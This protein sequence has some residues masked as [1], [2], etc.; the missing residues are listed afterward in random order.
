[1]KIVTAQDIQDKRVFIR[2][3]LDVPI[4][5]GVILDDFRL[6]AAVPTLNLCLQHAKQIV[7][8][9]H[10]GRPDGVEVPSLSVGPIYEWLE[11]HLGPEYMSGDHLQLLENLRFDKGE[12]FDTATEEEVLNQAKQLASLA[13]IYVNE[14]FASHHKSASTTVLPTLLPHFAGLRFAKEVQMLTMIRSN[15]LKPFISIV[16]GIKLEDKLP[17]VMVLAKVSDAVLVGGKI[18]DQ[19]KQS[20]QPI[21]ENI[22]PAELTPDGFDI[23][24]QTIDKWE[25]LINNSRMILWNGPMGKVEDPKN[26]QTKRLAELIIKSSAQTIVGGGDSISAL[27]KWGMI[28]KFNFVSTGGGAMLKFIES[29][30]LDTIKA[31]D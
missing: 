20:T 13:D 23:T 24:P 8:A 3:D 22:H 7:L 6:R 25:S 12:S 17:A 21:P 30:T 5:D 28:D 11:H 2:L 27:E 14:A 16:G 19:I 31:L 1:M 10:I 4:K 9:G 26:D 29:G 18:A 15:P